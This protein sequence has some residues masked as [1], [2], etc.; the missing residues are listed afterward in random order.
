[1]SETYRER[2]G[3]YC[4][5]LRAVGWVLLAGALAFLLL[6]AYVLLTGVS[7]GRF[8]SFKDVLVLANRDN[9]ELMRDSLMNWL[10][11]GVWYACILPVLNLPISLGL[12]LPGVWMARRYAP[13]IQVRAPSALELEMIHSGLNPRHLRRP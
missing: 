7:S 3:K 2:Q 4:P 10:S 11:P 5:G 8:S 1:M 9:F 13:D 12:G 6:D